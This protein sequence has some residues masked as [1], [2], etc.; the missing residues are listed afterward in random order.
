MAHFSITG[1]N[2]T[3]SAVMLASTS[4]AADAT[5]TSST[6]NTMQD[7]LADVSAALVDQ[8]NDTEA[9]EGSSFALIRPK[10]D[11]FNLYQNQPELREKAKELAERLDGPIHDANAGNFFYQDSMG[12]FLR[13]GVLTD[14]EFLDMAASM[15]DDE[16]A[17]FAATIKGM[18]L[19]ASSNYTIQNEEDRS[20]KDKVAEF[21]Q[22]LK[23]SDT[24]D[25]E[26]I[27][28]QSADYAAE[29]DVDDL[30]IFE[31]N[32]FGQMQSKAK[33]AP[34]RSETSSNNLHN[35]ISAVVAIDD[36]AALTDQLGH[37]SDDAQQGLL[38]VYGLD[39]ELGNR[40]AQLA[41]PE[42]NG[43][44]TSLLSALGSMADSVKMA[45]FISQVK[46]DFGQAWFGDEAL[47][48]DNEESQS[49]EF[50]LDS[51]TSMVSMLEQYDFSDEQLET[52]GSELNGLS[53]PDKRAYIEITA[54]GL[55]DMLQS[56]V[57]ENFDKKNLDEALE[58]VSNLRSNENVLSLVNGAT[59]MSP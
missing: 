33:Y 48:K 18:V 19:P 53:N 51:I 9:L 13:A 20:Y 50:A 37:M 43:L 56:K 35:Y 17:D 4:R 49:R 55:D 11:P 6:S 25:R 29:V 24:S 59:M 21:V 10:G 54:T 47:L 41:G 26:A 15:S 40:L 34:Y 38:S 28:Q 46:V 7:A 44:P 22:V 12:D 58:V 8:Q 3:Y 57:D 2:T 32:V 5:L 27:L 16:L 45:S 52:M 42:G 1:L 39:T 30:A 36:P 14:P 23:S 31:Q